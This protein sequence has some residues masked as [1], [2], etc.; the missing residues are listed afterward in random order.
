MWY[1]L[2]SA[3]DDLQ[4]QKNGMVCLYFSLAKTDLKKAYNAEF[5]FKSNRV[6]E[7]IPFWFVGLH[8]CF[9]K[10][11]LQTKLPNPIAIMQIAIGT[12]C[13]VRSRTHVGMF[14]SFCLAC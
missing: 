5:L 7:C 3:L 12:Q 13:R 8:L 11:T 4:T 2:M 1:V 6:Y 10:D 14:A 9:E